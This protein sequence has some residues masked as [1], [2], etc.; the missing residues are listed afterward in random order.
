MQISV[1]LMGILKDKTPTGEC[2]EL[3]DG[4]TIADALV[5]LDIRTDFVHVFTING[6]LQR[7]QQFVLSAN[8]E[9]CVLP[10]A[11]GG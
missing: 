2:L 10:P 8:D 5:A 6:Q 4:A 11:G 7:D 3:P 9:L 1:K